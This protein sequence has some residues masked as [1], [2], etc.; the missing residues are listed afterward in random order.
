MTAFLVSH[1]RDLPAFLKASC[2][3]WT[4]Y[5]VPSILQLLFLSNPKYNLFSSSFTIVGLVDGGV[6]DDADALHAYT[7]LGEKAGLS[8][9]IT[10]RLGGYAI[11]YWCGECP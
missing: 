6:D 8:H 9:V 11:R 1:D 4:T 10:G 2:P 3:H 5:H 7:R